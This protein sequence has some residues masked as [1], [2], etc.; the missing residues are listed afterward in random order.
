MIGFAASI[1]QRTFAAAGGRTV[2]DEMRVS[3]AAVSCCALAFGIGDI[4]VATTAV[5]SNVFAVEYVEAQAVSL[6]G[7]AN[8]ATVTKR[9]VGSDLRDWVESAIQGCQWV[10]GLAH[11]IASVTPTAALSQVRRG[12]ARLGV[13]ILRRVAVVVAG[14]EVL[15]T[16]ISGVVALTL[17]V[18]LAAVGHADPDVSNATSAVGGLTAR[19]CQGAAAVA[20]CWGKIDCRP[21]WIEL[22]TLSSGQEALA[23]ALVVS[24]AGVSAVRISA[25]A[26]TRGG[27]KLRSSL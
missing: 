23:D 5:Q 21:V 10:T 15:A 6:I 19:L 18:V 12:C 14:V 20:I 17:A 3:R 8:A 4:T 26:C 1:C 9:S 27:V 2:D 22:L 25:D 7:S 11:G 24:C 13:V 16:T